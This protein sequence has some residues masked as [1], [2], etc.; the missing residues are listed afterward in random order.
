[1]EVDRL[2]CL[3][4]LFFISLLLLGC[5]G[6]TTPFG[7]LE[8][9]KEVEVSKNKKKSRDVASKNRQKYQVL[10]HPSRQVLHDKADFLADE[11]A[12]FSQLA[13]LDPRTTSGSFRLAKDFAGL[14]A[15]IVKAVGG[16]TIHW[17]GAS[18]RFQPHEFKALSTYGKVTL[19]SATVD[20]YGTAPGIFATQ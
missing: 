10:F 6:P 13:W 7:A 20:V 11:W 15:W 9:V 17:A 4:G 5:V 12:S 19:V 2:K 1:M 3:S 14:P 16:T 8:E 18:L